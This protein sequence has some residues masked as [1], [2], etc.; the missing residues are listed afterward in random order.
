MFCDSSERTKREFKPTAKYDGENIMIS[1]EAGKLAITD[2][3]N[4]KFCT[5]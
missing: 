5:I 1:L 4:N 3:F 2:S